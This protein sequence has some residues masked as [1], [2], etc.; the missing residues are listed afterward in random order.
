MAVS[1]DAVVKQLL[2]EIGNRGKL[3]LRIFPEDNNSDQKPW[4][5][6]GLS[7]GK[8]DLLYGSC[9]GAWYTEEKW[10]DPQNKVTV[11]SK[12]IIAVEGTLALERGS[13]GSA[14]YQRFFHAL[15]AVLS[16]VIGI[17]YLRQQ[18]KHIY[19]GREVSSKIRYDLPMAALNAS[20]IHNTPYLVITNI[21]DI[22]KLVTDL[23]NENLVQVE[24][25]IKEIKEK[26]KKYFQDNAPKEYKNIEEYCKGR[27]IA[28][29]AKGNFIKI[30]STNYQNLTL[31]EKRGG[32]IMLGEYFIAKYMLKGNL[33]MFLP[34]L[35]R[36]DIEKLNA[37]N[38]KEWKV[39]WEDSNGMVLTIEDFDGISE[40]M[41][42]MILK[43]NS[44]SE[45]LGLIKVLLD[46]IRKNE[47]RIRDDFKPP[48]IKKVK[49][50][51]L[52]DF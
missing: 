11:D 13:T 16:G 46:K 43:C 48:V 27:S 33:I 24:K 9:D 32:H 14:Q 20:D 15:G 3:K 25:T 35:S 6:G 47:I 34:R 1:S 52:Q 29:D 30:L 19:K 12:P 36:K 17:Y 10:I 26:M 40:D 21:N 45:W 41:K 23:G 44:Y 49:I 38:K 37:S 5:D 42:R 31:S 28:K 18:E 4:I 2:Q 51:R 39:L 50:Q 22:K 7:F 8:R